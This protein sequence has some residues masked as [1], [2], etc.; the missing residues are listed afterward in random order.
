MSAKERTSFAPLCNCLSILFIG[1]AIGIVTGVL[2]NVI[3]AFVCVPYFEVVL[4]FSDPGLFQA[5]L[6]QGAIE[7]GILGSVFGLILM[8]VAAASTAGQCTVLFT[9]RTLAWCIGI[10]LAFWTLGGAVGVLLSYL[11]PG[12]W[13]SGGLFISIPRWINPHQFAWVGGTANA[14]YLGA[15]CSMV[16]API[17]LHLRWKR[18]H[19]P[20][21]GF[22]VTPLVRT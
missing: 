15:V 4:S 6:G 9:L 8:I 12:L 5:I 21:P 14:V 1:L 11:V 22:P 13:G 2:T 3:N 16:F 20:I 7:G 18:E 19:P 17:H 10:T